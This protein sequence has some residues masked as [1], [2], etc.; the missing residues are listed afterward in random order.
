MGFDTGLEEGQKGNGGEVN[1]SDISVESIGPLRKVL[2][3]PEFFFELGG[4]GGV[5]LDFGARDSRRGD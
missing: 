2:V 3:I 5:G 4:L 1:S